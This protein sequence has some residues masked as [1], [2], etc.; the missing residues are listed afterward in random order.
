[1]PY[2]SRMA[3]GYSKELRL[4]QGRAEGRAHASGQG[5]RG[6]AGVQEREEREREGEAR[7]LKGTLKGNSFIFLSGFLYFS[8]LCFLLHHRVRGKTGV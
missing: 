3:S 7:D 6:R 4:Y 5:Q 2:E 8:Y 1:M